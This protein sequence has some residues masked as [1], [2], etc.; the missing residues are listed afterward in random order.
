MSPSDVRSG[1]GGRR[2]LR[3]G[4][5]AD[6]AVQVGAPGAGDATGALSWTARDGGTWTRLDVVAG[7]CVVRVEGRLDIGALQPCRAAL[8]AAFAVHPVRIVVDLHCTDTAQPV[9]VALLAAAR[10][11]LR[12]RGIALTLT[13][14]PDAVLGALQDAH[15]VAL[16]DV[17]PTTAV[18]VGR[19]RVG[20]ARRPPVVRTA[21]PEPAYS[22]LPEA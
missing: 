22:P 1:P 4:D 12:A 5:A 11:Y 9:T 3:R 2:R 20:L 8:D 19:A 18:A 17:Q 6:D 7:V 21:V 15:I 13:A 14:V 16:F 10:R